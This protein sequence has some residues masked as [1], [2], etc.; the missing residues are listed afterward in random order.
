MEIYMSMHSHVIGIRPP[1]E[2][3]KKMKAA[4]DACEAA[5]LQIP[6]AVGDFFKWERPNDAG[7]VVELDQECCR[8]YKADMQEGFT[9]DVSKLPKDVR[10]VRFINSY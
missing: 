4:W 3:W 9:V 8:P 5:D 10:L 7:V 1:D 2:K 6:D